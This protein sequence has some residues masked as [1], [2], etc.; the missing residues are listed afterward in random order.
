MVLGV[1]GLPGCGKSAFCAGL[2]RSLWISADRLGH[3]LLDR[4]DLQKRLVD[5]FGL[6]ILKE[7]RVHRPTLGAIVFGGQGMETLNAIVHPAIREEV[8]RRIVEAR[9]GWRPV[10]LEAA[11]LFEAGFDDL[12]DRSLLLEADF[13]LRLARVQSRGW[14]REELKSRDLQ[15]NADLKRDRAIWRWGSGIDLKVMK[16]GSTLTDI[17]LGYALSTN[18]IE[19]ADRCLADLFY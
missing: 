17:A 13:D 6:E 10:V 8:H 9:S 12:C 11:I 3:E 4:P 16:R 18:R 5:A 14:S 15:Q 2:A 7:G 19:D 1:T